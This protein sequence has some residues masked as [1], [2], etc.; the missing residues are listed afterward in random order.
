[1]GVLQ[2]PRRSAVSEIAYLEPSTMSHSK[3]RKLLFFPILTIGLILSTFLD[4]VQWA[5]VMWL[6]NQTFVWAGVVEAGVFSTARKD[7]KIRSHSCCL[8]C[9]FILPKWNIMQCGNRKFPQKF[10]NR[11]NLLHW[12]QLRKWANTLFVCVHETGSVQFVHLHVYASTKWSETASTAVRFVCVCETET[13]YNLA[14]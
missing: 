11:K 9:W 12:N 1:M 13:E 7:I 5:A 14:M 4:L 3:L 6:T 2:T 10:L 8:K